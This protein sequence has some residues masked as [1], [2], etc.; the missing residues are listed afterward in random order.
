MDD[1]IYFNPTKLTIKEK[2]GNE[3]LDNI[4][5]PNDSFKKFV[6]KESEKMSLELYTCDNCG[7]GTFYNPSEIKEKNL[8]CRHCGKPANQDNLGN[9]D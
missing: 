5:D 6:H 2:Y 3:S 8:S 7:K 4:F 9:E 1:R